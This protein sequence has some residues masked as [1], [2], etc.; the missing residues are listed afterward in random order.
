MVLALLLLAL[1]PLPAWA[2]TAWVDDN[3]AA[4]WGACQ[5]STPLS[6]A[7]ACSYT[8]AMSN[9]T[10]GDTVYFR[11]GTYSVGTLQNHPSMAFIRIAP[12]NSGS[13][14]NPITFA[15]YTGEVAT[16]TAT[17][18]STS[19]EAWLGCGS[20]NSYIVWDGFAATMIVN[21]V[22]PGQHY[23]TAILALYGN[24]CTAKNWDFTGVNV[25]SWSYNTSFIRVE[26]SVSGNVITN[27]YFH[28]LTGTTAAV[29]TNAVWLFGTSSNT[30]IYNNTCAHMRNCFQ[31]KTDVMSATVYQNFIYSPANDECQDGF[32]IGYQGTSASGVFTAHH[33]VIVGCKN[34]IRFANLSSGSVASPVVHH[35]TIVA[36][37]Q[38]TQNG[39]FIATSGVTSLDL[40]DNIMYGA[41]PLEEFNTS[42]TYTRTDY[43]VFYHASAY[44]WRLDETT[45]YTTL[46]NW[47]TATSREA[48]SQTADPTFVNASGTSAVDYRLQAGSPALTASTSGGQVGAYEGN[49]CIGQGCIVSVTGA[50]GVSGSTR[51]TGSVRIQ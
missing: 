7:S 39:V 40:Y 47:R 17:V 35:N 36:G 4:A 5:G 42:A 46:A 21:D 27:N 33:N 38:G 16:W 15:A 44:R 24:N 25:G 2:A 9:A 28:D 20:G 31:G 1:L 48:N 10:A 34:G 23:E 43:N 26:G 29:S 18:T 32:Y 6:G 8:T 12:T 37:S 19:Q 11:T 41:S 3:G 30:L 50:L 14:G 13:A 51:F 22:D 49:S 45:A